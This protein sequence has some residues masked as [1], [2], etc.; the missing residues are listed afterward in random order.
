VTVDGN[1]FVSFVL[2]EKRWA[3]PPS[4]S[5]TTARTVQADDSEFYPLQVQ[6]PKGSILVLTLKVRTF[7]VAEG[8]LIFRHPLIGDVYL[9]ANETKTIWFPVND[10]VRIESFWPDSNVNKT[11]LPVYA[12][13]QDWR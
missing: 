3:R 5:R 4:G 7:N 8:G 13:P 9:D 2:T 11:F 12:I 1:E 10:D 6:V